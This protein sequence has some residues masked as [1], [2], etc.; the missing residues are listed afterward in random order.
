[1]LDEP[2][3]D[4]AMASKS[5][6]D[7]LLEAPHPWDPRHKKLRPL[8]RLLF[9]PVF[10]TVLVP[11]A[12]VRL[13]V[14]AIASIGVIFF[15]YVCRGPLRFL[16]VPAYTL[17]GRLVL[18]SFGVWPGM[19]SVKGKK[20][21]H[22]CP[23]CVAA[24][25][26]GMLDAFFFMYHGLPRP[27]AIESYAKI[28]VVGALFAAAN[29]I[30]VPVARAT[31]KG[32]S[33][34]ALPANKGG[35]ASSNGSSGATKEN[36]SMNTAGA[37]S[38][39]KAPLVAEMSRGRDR[40]KSLSKEEAGATIV[41]PSKP[42]GGSS[43]TQAVR[44]AIQ[45]TKRKW[46]EDLDDAARKASKPILILPEGTT[47]AGQC[48]MKFF[49]GA[50]EGGG[51]IQPVLLQYPYSRYNLAFFE[52]GLP[53]HI[54]KL[55]LAPWV[56]IDV[57]YLPLCTPTADEARE[58]DRYAE[59]VRREMAAASNLPLSPFGARDLRKQSQERSAAEAAAKDRRD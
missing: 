40:H 34:A 56:K 25:H 30:A 27:M 9:W 23:V 1:M 2:T 59:R 39:E 20:L 38:P 19:I 31:N 49:S 58:P 21:W 44:A 6:T 24:P 42:A 10:C 15:A 12:C 16:L 18:F 22:L 29:G 14:L 45:E 54:G 46:L 5:E 11:L 47:Q 33:S 52:K 26:Y 3:T 36:A 55:L 28:P 51:P 4:G 17:C 8:E 13:V 53:D 37:P 32:S 50:F 35:V 57:T 43:A 41:A 7:T 48:L